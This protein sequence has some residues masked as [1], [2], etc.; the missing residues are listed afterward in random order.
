MRNYTLI[1]LALTAV[2][3]GGLMI[4]NAHA[5]GNAGG[6]GWLFKCY[7]TQKLVKTYNEYGT[8]VTACS[9]GWQLIDNGWQRTCFNKQECG[10]K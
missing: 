10:T 7:S 4:T 6:F 9:D 8:Q 5:Y 2:T 1:L 3:L